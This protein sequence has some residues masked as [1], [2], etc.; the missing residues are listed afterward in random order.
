MS[1]LWPGGH[2]PWILGGKKKKSIGK[3]RDEDEREI[4]HWMNKKCAA[5]LIY[6]RNKAL[7]WNKLKAIKNKLFNFNVN[8][9]LVLHFL[10][11]QYQN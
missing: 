11:S 5:L 10:D 4:S 6:T 2:A 9:V 8:Q 3:L 7:E 1:T